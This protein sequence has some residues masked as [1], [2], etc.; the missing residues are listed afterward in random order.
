LMRMFRLLPAVSAGFRGNSRANSVSFRSVAEA[1][2]KTV[3]PQV[4]FD[5]LAYGRHTALPSPP[6]ADT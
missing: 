4:V 1:A 2:G 3:A 6:G 5:R